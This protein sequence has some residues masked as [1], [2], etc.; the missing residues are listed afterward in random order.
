MK[1]LIELTESGMKIMLQRLKE[2]WTDTN[3]IL[4]NLPRFIWYAIYCAIGYIMGYIVG[5]W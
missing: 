5:S 1:E 4:E 3:I 2:L